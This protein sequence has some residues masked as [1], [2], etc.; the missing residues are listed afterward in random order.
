MLAFHED[1]HVIE[2]P[3]L[4]EA[5]AHQGGRRR[6][7]EFDAAA[8]VFEVAA[9]AVHRICR[10]APGWPA[11]WCRRRPTRSSEPRPGR[12]VG[13]GN[14]HH[15]DLG[16]AARIDLAELGQERLQHIGNRRLISHDER[17][18]DI[19]RARRDRHTDLPP[20]VNRVA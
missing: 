17:Q 19:V 9:G 16:H 11:R 8:E 20:G 1:K 7:V 3:D 2:I 18:P 5:I 12:V 4:H 14:L 6:H 13:P 10:S 15:V